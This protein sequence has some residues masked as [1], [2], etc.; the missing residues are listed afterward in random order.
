M[1]KK[2][3]MGWLHFKPGKRDAFIAASRT[4]IETCRAEPGCEFFEFSVSPFDPDLA[5]VMECFSD[6]R[7]HE[8]VH[9]KTEHFR[10]FWKDLGEVCIEGRFQNIL[11]DTVEPDRHVFT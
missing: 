3:I 2:F 6:R 10:K 5:T 7:T 1:P 11:S 4:Y 9:L 8:E